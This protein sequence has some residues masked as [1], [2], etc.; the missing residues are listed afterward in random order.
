MKVK[1]EL[2]STELKRLIIAKIEETLGTVALD[3]SKVQIMVKSKQNGLS[4]MKK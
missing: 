3:E 4:L 1:I 2:D